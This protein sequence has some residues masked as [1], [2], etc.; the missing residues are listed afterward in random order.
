MSVFVAAA[1]V[2]VALA[3]VVDKYTGLSAVTFMF[4]TTQWLCF[5]AR[6]EK[7]GCVLGTKQ[8]EAVPWFVWLANFFD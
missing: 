6:L 3:T 4:G 5:S 8:N 7:F 2:E 1:D